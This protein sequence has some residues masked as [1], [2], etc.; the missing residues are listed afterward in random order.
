M[1]E[2][3]ELNLVSEEDYNDLGRAGL[4][5]CLL[6]GLPDWLVAY[7]VRLVCALPCCAV[8]SMLYI[9]YCS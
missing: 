9:C 4:G 6:G 3:C 8:K 7:V 2:A 1:L 5:S